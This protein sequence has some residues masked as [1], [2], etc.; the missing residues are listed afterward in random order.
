M[1]METENKKPSASLRALWLTMAL[2][3]VMLVAACDLA[4]GTRVVGLAALMGATG[5]LTV[6]FLTCDVYI[7]VLDSI[8]SL[9]ILYFAAGMTATVPAV[10]AVSVL[11]AF[12]LSRMIKKRCAK[13]SAT[14]AVTLVLLL[15]FIL[16]AL[17]LYAAGGHSLAPKDIMNEIN[18]YF[19]T[20]KEQL[21]NFSEEYIDALPDATKKYY[22]GVGISMEELR[23]YYAQSMST[24]VDT[25]QMLL[26]GEIL[27]GLQLLAY[28]AVCIFVLTVKLA[29]YD[30]L[31]PEPR[32]VLYPTQITCIVFMAATFVYVIASFFFRSSAVTM[33][34]V[35][36]LLVLW[37][38][39]TACGVRGLIVRLKHPVLRRQTIFIL[40]LFVLFGLF[41]LNI[42]L[43]VSAILLAFLGARDVSSLRMAEAEANKKKK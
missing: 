5:I 21:I 31:L 11:C 9:L 26:P 33:V 38:S 17:L 37:P 41:M 1:N 22:E 35:N 16:L 23:E 27:L 24:S 36:L 43:P 32:W 18:G 7:S 20:I 3:A 28:L 34:V 8:F 30:A 6:I 10:G 19:E 15:Y 25:I 13:T 39:M 12:V 4:W 29:K 40:A 2:C 42:M 14:V